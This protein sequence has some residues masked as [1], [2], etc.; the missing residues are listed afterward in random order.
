MFDMIICCLQAASGEYVH[1]SLLRKFGFCSLDFSG[2]FLPLFVGRG[3]VQVLSPYRATSVGST[4]KG[5][6]STVEMNTAVDSQ[7]HGPGNTHILFFFCLIILSQADGS[8]EPIMTWS[9]AKACG[10]ASSMDSEEC[11][12]QSA[13]RFVFV[14]A[15]NQPPSGS[16]LKIY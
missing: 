7:C 4:L 8:H 14:P 5:E 2:L 6:I 9:R 11:R 3:E 15:K 10:F 1:Y 12:G 13:Q 16:Y